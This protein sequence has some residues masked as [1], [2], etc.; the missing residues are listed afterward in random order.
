[1]RHLAVCVSVCLCAPPPPFF[2]FSMLFVSCQKKA[3]DY[4]FPE[5]LIILSFQLRTSLYP[6]CYPIKTFCM[7]FPSLKYQ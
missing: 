4:F 1:M 6:S 5:L 2:S 7:H 3:G